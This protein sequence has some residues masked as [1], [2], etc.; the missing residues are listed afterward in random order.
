MS[1]RMPLHERRSTNPR[2]RYMSLRYLMRRLARSDNLSKVEN[3]KFW[4]D[5]ARFEKKERLLGRTYT[6]LKGHEDEQSSPACME[7]I[8]V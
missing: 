5:R 1:Y 6:K 2:L 3:A 4:R 7:D 8:L